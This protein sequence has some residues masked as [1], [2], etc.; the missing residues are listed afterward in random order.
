[1]EYL[2]DNPLL[3]IGLVLAT[4]IGLFIYFVSKEM[5]NLP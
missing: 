2:S 3:L 4:L 1:M 5:D